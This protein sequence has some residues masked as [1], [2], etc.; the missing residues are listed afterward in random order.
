[1]GQ[2]SPE[3]RWRELYL[4]I[5]PKAT[6]IPT[7][8]R[9]ITTRP[10]IQYLT[11]SIDYDGYVPECGSEGLDFN[12][13]EN[14]LLSEVRNALEERVDEVLEEHRNGFLEIVK[15]SLERLK[16]QFFQ[17]HNSSQTESSQPAMEI[18]GFPDP[19]FFDF[20]QLADQSNFDYNDP[21]WFDPSVE[22]RNYSSDISDSAYVSL[23]SPKSPLKG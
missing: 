9:F 19:D 7:S 22:S 11:V 1:M 3:E 12:Y 16:M 21:Y 10:E 2:K 13:L 20:S 23:D 18:P 5:F 4:I 6:K 15:T 14:E 17:Q 8:C